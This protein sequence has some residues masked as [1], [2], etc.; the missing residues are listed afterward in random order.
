MHNNPEKLL[1]VLYPRVALQCLMD[2]YIR[3]HHQTTNFGQ[4]VLQAHFFSKSPFGDLKFSCQYIFLL[5]MATKMVAAQSAE[6]GNK[7]VKIIHLHVHVMRKQLC[8]FVTLLAHF[9][10]ETV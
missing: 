2:G 1:A 3:V 9:F 10:A 7:N 8:L 5:A 4:S 6:S